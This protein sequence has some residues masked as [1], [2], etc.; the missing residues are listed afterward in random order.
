MGG[1]NKKTDIIDT[2][3]DTQKILIK[4]KR[5]LLFLVMVLL[6]I[7]G[8]SI[9]MAITFGPAK[10][11]PFE[12]FK[13][14]IYQITGYT[15]NG[16]AIKLCEGFLYDIVWLIRFPRIILAML[17]GAGLS[18]VGIIMQAV[19]KNP[20]ANPYTLGV[21]A[22]ASLGATLAIMLGVG[23]FLGD[24]FVGLTA[25]IGAFLCSISVYIISSIGGKSNTVKLLLSGMAFSA[26]CS[27]FSN[28]II[29]IASDA[30]GMKSL[31][32]WLMGS[33]AG[34]KWE[35]LP[36]I[37]IVVIVGILFFLTQF[38]NLNILL[39]GDE[40]ALSLGTDLN[41][42]RKFYLIITSLITGFIISTA[43]TI[44]FVGLII[45]HIVRMLIGTDHKKLLPISIIIGAI[46]MIW[47]DVIARTLLGNGELPIGIVTSMIGAPFFIWLMIKQTYAFGT[48]E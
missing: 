9:V 25:C 6:S 29:Y 3:L 22:G 30:E 42:Y 8:L 38:R 7:L 37:S 28:F 5:S 26:I 20:L 36:I 23:S 40:V 34:I 19:V 13:V 31:S 10:L 17:V 11:N 33:L 41:K 27:A 48:K 12:I 24:N 35:G 21:S 2:N 15:F 44:G 32:F 16:E 46:F 43:G 14:L 18:T 4:K 47:C 1:F 39:L 45:P